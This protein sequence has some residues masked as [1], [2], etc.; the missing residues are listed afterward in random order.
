MRRTEENPLQRLGPVE[1]SVAAEVECEDSVLAPGTL[2]LQ[3]AA[4]SAC[5]AGSVGVERS[6]REDRGR[7]DVVYVGE[8][9]E[10][11]APNRRAREPA[12]YSAREER[13]LTRGVGHVVVEW[14]LHGL[15][16]EV[17]LPVPV[18]PEEDAVH[19]DEDRCT[20]S[21]E[22]V[23]VNQTLRWHPE[24]AEERARTRGWDE[25]QLKV[26]GSRQ[27]EAD[28]HVLHGRHGEL[29]SKPAVPCPLQ[30]ALHEEP[31]SKRERV[32]AVEAPLVAPPTV[33][34]ESGLVEQEHQRQHCGKHQCQHIYSSIAR[35]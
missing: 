4:A 5:V 14:P 26:D 32:R 6:E 3:S 25:Q 13:Q 23:P 12:E 2:Q 35:Q 7:S 15:I 31:A 27:P 16:Q 30:H 19:A 34:G 21:E 24:Q 28:R 9:L 20:S 11:E 33:F 1:E 22:F 29:Q 18:D 10:V 17:A 8:P